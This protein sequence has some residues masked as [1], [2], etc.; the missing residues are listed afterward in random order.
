MNVILQALRN[1]KRAK[2]LQSSSFSFVFSSL[3]LS[4][5]LGLCLFLYFNGNVAKEVFLISRAMF[6]AYIISHMII[7]TMLKMLHSCAGRRDDVYRGMDV[8]FGKL[9]EFCISVCVRV[10]VPM[11][12][13]QTECS[14]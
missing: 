14:K 3:F 10:C 5:F 9:V 13:T 1:W 11:Q 7:R 8:F 2:W 6:V 12:Q 4:A